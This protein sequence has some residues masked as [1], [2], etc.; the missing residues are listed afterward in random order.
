MKLAI[1]FGPGWYDILDDNI[2]DLDFLP[3]VKLLGIPLVKIANDSRLRKREIVLKVNGNVEWQ[4]NFA[5]NDDYN[6]IFDIVLDN[7]RVLL[8]I[9]LDN[10]TKAQL[11]D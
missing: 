6:V 3:K 5:G 2:I 11:S 4:Q 9:V 1:V 8:N 10:L 7:I